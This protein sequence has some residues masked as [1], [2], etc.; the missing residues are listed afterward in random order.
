MDDDRVAAVIARARRSWERDG[1]D[2][3]VVH[4][5]CDELERERWR[6]ATLRVVNEVLR[7]GLQAALRP[8]V[9][10]KLTA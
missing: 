1:D 6:N 4:R 3:E 7:A 9:T 5:L 10:T 2:G 8:L